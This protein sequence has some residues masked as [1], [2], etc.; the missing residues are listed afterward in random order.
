MKEGALSALASG[1]V[2]WDA[3]R[4]GQTEVIDLSGAAV[5]LD[6]SQ[7]AW[8][9]SGCSLRNCTIGGAGALQLDV[10][11]TDLTAAGF[12]TGTNIASLLLD[13][14]SSLT[15]TRFDDITLSGVNFSA[16]ALSGTSFFR[17]VLRSVKF[18]R[19]LERVNFGR[20][21]LNDVDFCDAEFLDCAFASASANG[22]RFDNVAFRS[23]SPVPA[24]GAEP[25]EMTLEQ[26]LLRACTFLDAKF[27]GCKLLRTVFVDCDLRRASG[28]ALDHTVL[29]G[30]LQSPDAEDEWSVLQRSYT[31][32]NMVF[33]LIAM[34]I[35]FA[36]WIAQ[37]LYW[38]TVNQVQLGLIDGAAKV[39]AEVAKRPVETEQLIA[40]RSVLR[41]IDP[42]FKAC[43]RPAAGGTPPDSQAC[44]PV[45]Q[46]LIGQH[47]GPWA[48]CLSILLLV[49]N[50]A[51]LF[52]TWRVAPLRDDEKRTWQSPARDSYRWMIIV[53]RAVRV[54]MWFAILAAVLH[55]G[56]RLL[57][58]VWV[59]SV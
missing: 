5:A 51:R 14:R 57:V 31:G 28:I 4:A 37:A 1:K 33:N 50:G 19:N 34:I 13:E 17:S 23:S 30:T 54:L 49:Y 42:Q 58:P 25:M 12:T 29:R 48:V 41:S 56:P 44:R 21:S 24:S 18:G 8:N 38:S 10:R 40:L 47:E 16:T 52:L 43:I 26:A 6:G 59:G 39:E 22:C 15:G 20:A 3:W 7:G 36:P 46:V 2:A 35:F 45:W 11:G 9:L 32:A 55:L 53:H 27:E